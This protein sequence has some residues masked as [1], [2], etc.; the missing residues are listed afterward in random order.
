MGHVTASP[1]SHVDA[2]HRSSQWCAQSW[3]STPV[4]HDLD[5]VM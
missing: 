5:D 2:G 1:R 4:S 3:S